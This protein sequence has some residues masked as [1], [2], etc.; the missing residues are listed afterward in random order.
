MATCC[1]NKTNTDRSLNIVTYNMHGFNQGIST[2]KDLTELSSPDIFMLQEHWL[3]PANLCKFNEMFPAYFGFGISALCNKVESGPLVGRPYGGAFILLK[4]ELLSVSECIHAAERF[5]IVRVGN[6]IFVNIYL[7]CTGTVDRELISDEIFAEIS[8]WKSK[9][10]YCGC[11]V[12]G[13][14]NSDLDRRCNS[15]TVINKFLTDNNLTRCDVLNPSAIPYTFVNESMSHYSK[16]D[17]IAFDNVNVSN[18]DVIESVA[19]L[20]DHLPLTAVC[21]CSIDPSIIKSNVQSDRE[22]VQHLRWDHADII[23]YY[24]S[25]MVHMQSILSELQHFEASDNVEFNDSVMFID[26][27][28]HKIIVALQN[29]AAAYVPT[30]NVNFYKY[31]WS[32]ELDCLKEKSIESDKVWKASG[33]PRSGPIFNKRSADKRAYKLGIRKS[34]SDSA[35]NYS[36]ELHE[37]LLAKNGNA[38]WK[39]WKSKF[40]SQSPKCQQV[41]GL[42]D[43]QQIADKFYEHFAELSSAAT[44][45][46]GTDTRSMHDAYA[47]MRPIYIGS[48]YT[49]KH[50]IDAELVEHVILDL[51]RGK[52]AGLDSLTAEHLQHCHELLPCVLAKLFNL[53]VRYG[54]V[55]T[56]FG[57]SDYRIPLTYYLAYLFT[58]YLLRSY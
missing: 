1:N 2:I 21:A 27:V 37:A 30:R 53:I 28:Y 5:V 47:N 31:W 57:L 25:T 22:S 34:Q 50:L 46:A 12:A 40:Q 3:T 18:Y 42:T 6:V 55:P 49:E 44:A 38:F 58:C 56:D 29:S 17:Y 52:A 35:H 11:I 41:G 32:Q 48:P 33:R 7:P 13:D 36:N 15:S 54:Y 43:F 26:V 8:A 4:T 24:N 19:N 14:F 9:F 20:S 10:N 16:L 39:C 23:G 51:Q 45:A